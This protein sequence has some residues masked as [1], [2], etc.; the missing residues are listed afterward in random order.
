MLLK[1]FL[2]VAFEEIEVHDRRPVGLAEVARYPL[3]TPE[4]LDFLR[5]VLAPGRHDEIVWSIVVTARRPRAR[6]EPRRCG[7]C[8][9][10]NPAGAK[11]CSECGA[12]LDGAASASGSLPEPDALCD[13][14]AGGC[15][16]GALLKVRSLITA[17]AEGQV[18]EIRSSDPGVREDVPAWCRMTGHAFLGS[19]GPRY[20][21]RK[22]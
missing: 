8:H 5:Q 16:E 11:F 9:Y 3:F 13:L 2:N 4:F 21:V 20:F 7:M 6:A 18:L 12:R 15:E 22:R 1:K 17:L 14:G 19:A 10:D